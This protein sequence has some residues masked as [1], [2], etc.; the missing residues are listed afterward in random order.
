[1]YILEAFKKQRDI[2]LYSGVEQSGVLAGPITLRSRGSNPA[3]A[4][5]E[6]SP[7]P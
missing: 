5:Y 4:S 3:P 7:M 6:L 2:E 1:M